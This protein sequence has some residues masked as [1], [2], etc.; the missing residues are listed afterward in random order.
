M[1]RFK[2]RLCMIEACFKAEERLQPKVRRYKTGPGRVKTMAIVWMT[3]A[4][5]DVLSRMIITD[6]DSS[7]EQRKGRASDVGE[8]DPNRTESPGQSRPGLPNVE[9]IILAYLLALSMRACASKALVEYD[10]NC[11]DGQSSSCHGLTGNMSTTA[12]NRIAFGHPRSVSGLLHG[13]SVLGQERCRRG[14]IGLAE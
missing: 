8:R 7:S 9:Y 5:F 10:I 13:W 1:L 14:D 11:M 12:W 4:Y 3:T 6:Q 2:C